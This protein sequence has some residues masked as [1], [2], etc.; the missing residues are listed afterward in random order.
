MARQAKLRLLLGLVGFVGLQE[1][2]ELRQEAVAFDAVHHAGLLHGF[3]PGRGAAQAVHTDGEEQGSGLRRYV[4]NVADD[5][6]FFNFNS[7]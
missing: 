2:V 7:H 6:F 1:V 4:Q 3:T 5:G